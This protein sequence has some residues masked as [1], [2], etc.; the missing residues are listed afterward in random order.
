MNHCIEEVSDAR[1]TFQAV[2]YPAEENFI[3]RQIVEQ[4]LDWQPNQGDGVATELRFPAMLDI[5]ARLIE[6][7]PGGETE[8]H[9]HSYEAFFYVLA[10]AGS[11]R[12][13]DSN[14]NRRNC[15]RSGDLFVT[16]RQTWHQLINDSPTETVRLLEIS[17]AP[18]MA[19]NG[20]SSLENGAGK[21]S[22]PGDFAA[23][24]EHDD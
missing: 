17:T 23:G 7:A 6:I 9:R 22:K 3:S 10:G 2:A 13:G 21:L 19:A 8:L 16:P 11:T 20:T 4:T 5:D 24:F 1:S 18:L 15:W 14:A 12:A